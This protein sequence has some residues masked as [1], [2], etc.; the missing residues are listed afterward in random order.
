MKIDMCI[1]FLILPKRPK[2]YRI[3]RTKSKRISRKKRKKELHKET[4]YQNGCFIW[5]VCMACIRL[6][7]FGWVAL[8]FKLQF[9]F[10]ADSSDSCTLFLLTFF[11][12]SLSPSLFI[13]WSRLSCILIHTLQFFCTFIC[14]IR[15]NSSEIHSRENFMIQYNMNL[16]LTHR[17]ACPDILFFIFCFFFFIS[18]NFNHIFV[19]F[20]LQIHHKPRIKQDALLATVRFK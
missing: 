17:D 16:C 5:N 13:I 9:W 12:L 1:W 15:L 4:H 8:L 7:K 20:L 14:I 6:K 11:S 18:K 2:G 3:N 19:L 10:M